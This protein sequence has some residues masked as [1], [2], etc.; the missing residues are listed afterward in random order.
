[1][2]LKV[3]L[4]GIGKRNTAVRGHTV[5]LIFLS[6]KIVQ[7]RWTKNRAIKMKIMRT[8]YGYLVRVGMTSQ[9]SRKRHPFNL[10]NTSSVI[11]LLL[12]ISSP[13]IFL[14]YGAKNLKETADTIYIIISVSTGMIN[15]I[16]VTWNMA[17]LFRFI[18]NL[19]DIVHTS[20]SHGDITMKFNKIIWSNFAL[21]LV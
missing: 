15:F 1:M 17:E 14:I 18:E 10:R 6:T 20:K 12:N 16:Y 9:Q 8:I 5:R 3:N 21:R 19:D 7:Q 13:T 4:N 11:V 2:V